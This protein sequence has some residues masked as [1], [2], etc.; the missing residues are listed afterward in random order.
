VTFLGDGSRASRPLFA[1]LGVRVGLSRPLQQTIVRRRLW[2]VY[3]LSRPGY[4][5]PEKIFRKKLSP[6]P[7]ALVTSGH[8]RPHEGASGSGSEVRAGS[9][10]CAAGST[11]PASR[12]AVAE[13]RMPAL[14]VPLQGGGRSESLLWSGAHGIA[15]EHNRPP[16]TMTGRQQPGFDQ[17]SLPQRTAML[18]RSGLTGHAGRDRQKSPHTRRRA[19]GF[20]NFRNGRSAPVSSRLLFFARAGVRRRWRAPGAMI[21]K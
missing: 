8:P 21:L 10:A 15:A 5:A 9:G 1:R 16:G 20:L 13:R 12:E 3:V 6:S 7:R 2:V 19:T 4:D 18:V 14:S 11:C 17:T